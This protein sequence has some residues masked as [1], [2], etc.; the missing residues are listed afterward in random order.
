MSKKNRIREI[1]PP[2]VTHDAL[3]GQSR[4]VVTDVDHEAKAITVTGVAEFGPEIGLTRIEQIDLV[5]QVNS[6]LTVDVSEGVVLDE[7]GARVGADLYPWAN[8]RR[9]RFA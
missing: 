8:I 6:R 3:R 1:E 9:V 4:M 2:A 7:L 5:H